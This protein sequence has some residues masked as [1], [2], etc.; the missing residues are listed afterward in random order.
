MPE[1]KVNEVHIAKLESNFEYL[2][3]ELERVNT[4]ITNL[5]KV[6]FHGNGTP[7]L[8]QQMVDVRADIDNIN[9]VVHEKFQNMDTQM[10][11]KFA[12]LHDNI[13]SHHDLLTTQLT[14]EIDARK[15]ELQ[16]SWKLRATMVTAFGAIVVALLSLFS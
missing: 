2:Q 3:A 8:P 16:G 9:T 10:N 6:I 12:N 5:N 14:S 4:S 13:K 15:V 11:L 7:P 1:G